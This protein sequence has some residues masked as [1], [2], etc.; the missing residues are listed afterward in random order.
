VWKN[1]Q[2]GQPYDLEDNDDVAQWTFMITR[3]DDPETWRQTVKEGKTAF[4]FGAYFQYRSQDFEAQNV[5]LGAGTDLATNYISR[6]ASMYIP[7][8]WARFTTSN[9]TLETELVGIFGDIDNLNPVSADPT[10]APKQ[11]FRMLGGVAKLDWSMLDDD[12]HLE[13]ELGF[14]SGDEWE[15]ENGVI[16]VHE[17]N[18]FPQAANDD[19]ITNFRFNYDYR[20]DLIFF[21]EI[22]GAI[23]NATYVKPS[24]S[25][26]VTDRIHFKL[27]GIAS[28]S[29]VPVST[30][31]NDISGR[32]YGIE[33]DAELGYGNKD[34][35]FF[36]GLYYGVFF[37]FGALNYPV[38]I[39]PDSV[40]NQHEPS[41][42]QTI[43]AKLLLKF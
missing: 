15:S 29:N 11:K 39:F 5:K 32:L 19:T 17:A 16:N 13:L 35:G 28:F 37:P 4:N 24:V 22:L 23:T 18:Y 6:K 3:I 33:L 1:R 36:A 20:V 7:D 9:L 43:Q 2:G 25:Y 27:A 42:A 14:A 31:G 8:V 26:N 41:T 21:R 12:L 40:I 10:Q 34:D 30:P 38:E